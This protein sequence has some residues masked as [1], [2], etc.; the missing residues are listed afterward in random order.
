MNIRNWLSC[1][2]LFCAA[3]FAFP[4][5]AQVT[6]QKCS[7]END[8]SIRLKCYDGLAGRVGSDTAKPTIIKPEAATAPAT[9][10]GETAKAPAADSDK[11]PISA[12][13]EPGQRRNLVDQ[14]LL[15]ETDG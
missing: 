2:L 4:S 8:P 3:T 13:V 5:I 10:P 12:L 15:N 11:T 14:W 9:K 1:S 7:E 6:L